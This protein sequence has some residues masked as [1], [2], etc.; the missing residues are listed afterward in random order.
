MSKWFSPEWTLYNEC[1]LLHFDREKGELLERRPDRVMTK[2]G[3]TIV[4]DFK[5]G[6][7]NPEYHDQVRGYIRQ[8]R[9]MG[10][11]DVEGYL[12]YVYKNN[13]EKVEA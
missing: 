9:D 6:N 12:W 4:I 10:H 7:P 2:D 11:H 1:T 3:K 13:I 5:F 8:L